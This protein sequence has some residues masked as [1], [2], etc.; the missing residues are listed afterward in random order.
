[1]G[2]HQF[3]MV[4]KKLLSTFKYTCSLR[5]ISQAMM[6]SIDIIPKQ[7]TLIAIQKFYHDGVEFF[8]TDMV[9]AHIHYFPS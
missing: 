2:A 6:E 1:M 7:T 9:Y 4:F 8:I 3:F 5:K